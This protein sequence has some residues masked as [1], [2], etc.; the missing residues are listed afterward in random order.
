[1]NYFNFFKLIILDKLVEYGL[2][3]VGGGIEILDFNYFLGLI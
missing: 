3:G 2:G 1:M